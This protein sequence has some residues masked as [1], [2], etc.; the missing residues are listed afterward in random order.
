MNQENS[1]HDE[2]YAQSHVRKTSL[3]WLAHWQVFLQVI[4]ISTLGSDLRLDMPLSQ[5]TENTLLDE[6]SIF[7]SAGDWQQKT[8]RR[9]GC[10]A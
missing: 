3:K 10:S 1:E 8:D 5:L 6:W 2:H 4:I 7:D 9:T